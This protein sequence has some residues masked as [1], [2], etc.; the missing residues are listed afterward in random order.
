MADDV[1]FVAERALRSVQWRAK[2]PMQVEATFVFKRPNVHVPT[3][4]PE[5]WASA[6]KY[7]ASGSG[8]RQA[9]S[10]DL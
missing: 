4:R 2:M 3:I 10:S 9:L 7:P 8:P 1:K 5:S 6:L